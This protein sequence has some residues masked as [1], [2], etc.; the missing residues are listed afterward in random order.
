MRRQRG[1][2]LLEIMVALMI[3]ATAAVALSNSLSEATRSTGALEQRQFADLLAQNL[4][5]DISR[6]GYGNRSIG[7][8]RLAGYDF[9]W[10]RQLSDTPQPSIQR[11]DISIQLAGE[12]D[13][14]A[15]RSAFMAKQG[16]R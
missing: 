3:F 4:L 6:E 10:R 16:G 5:I 7:E 1:F 9:V 11:V 12:D 8:A 2:T 14:L 13:T 15:S